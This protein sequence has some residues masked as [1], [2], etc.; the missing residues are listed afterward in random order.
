MMFESV[1]SVIKG[2]DE[3]GY[4]CDKRIATVVFLA[5]QLS[6]PVLIEEC[7]QGQAANRDPHGRP[8]LMTS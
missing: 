5:Q 4:I 2:L 8:F 3:L 1:N 6:K 7:H